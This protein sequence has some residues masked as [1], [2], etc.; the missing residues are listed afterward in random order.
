MTDPMPSAREMDFLLHDWLRVADLASRDAYAH[1]DR[2]TIGQTLDLARALAADRFWPHYAKA[3][4]EE[5]RVENGR[6]RLVPE[7]ADAVAAFRDA[8]FFGMSFTEGDGGLG[9]PW[10][11]TQAACTLFSA[12]NQGTFA[13]P[14][15]TIAAANLLKVFGTDAQK[16]L[17]MQPMIEGRFFGT[18][19]LSEPHAGSSLADIRTRAIPAGDGT[20]RLKGTKM[21]ISGGE[22]E[23]AP[24]IVHLVLARIE[25]APA[26]VKGISLFAVPRYRLDADGNPGAANG[27]TLAGLNHKMG[28]R[29]T[30]NTLLNFGEDADCIGTLVGEEHRGL[31][32]MFHM[33]NEARLGVGLSAAAQACAGYR[34]SLDYARE[35]TQGRP[36]DAK[37]PAAPPVPIIAHADVR[38]MLLAQKAYAEGGLALGLWLARLIDEQKTA[39]DRGERA[40]LTGLLDLLTPVMKAWTSHYGLEANFWAIQI[41]GGAGYTRDFPVEQLYRDNR[42][43]PIHEGTNGIQ[44]IDLLGRKLGLR[45]GADWRELGKLVRATAKRAEGG[46][47]ADLGAALAEAMDTADRVAVTLAKRGAAQ[48]PGP[49]LANAWDFLRLTGHTVIAWVWLEQALVASEGAGGDPYLQGKIAAARWFFAHELPFVEAWADMLAAGDAPHL[50]I[51]D[52]GF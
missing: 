45:D 8:G 28:Y 48:G 1:A 30:V 2:E 18:M 4:A 43:N 42:L 21:W 14:F 12:A 16:R 7:A 5:P 32:A 34:I 44:A 51:P 27:V 41:L 17:Y 47:L 6:V 50:D 23:L 25:G 3:D 33:M 19:C 38:R 13:Y 22:H 29:G 37:D 36:A 26:G 52:D 20:Y 31:F 35:R 49:M 10:V 39:E 40:R 46:G 15:L 9:L 24:N 11:V